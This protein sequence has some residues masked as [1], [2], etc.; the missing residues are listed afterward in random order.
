MAE[1]YSANDRPMSAIG[2]G[3]DARCSICGH[4]NML[5]MMKVGELATGIEKGSIATLPRA[6]VNGRCSLV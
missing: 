6:D 1:V 4:S 2:L 5:V 3:L